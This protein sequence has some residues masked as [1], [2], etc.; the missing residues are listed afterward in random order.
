MIGYTELETMISFA[1]KLL[2]YFTRG[3]QFCSIM[4]LKLHIKI[5]ASLLALKQISNT[6][7]TFT[8][9]DIYCVE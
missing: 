7:L 3:T 1:I 8:G 9:F 5:L 2:P 4:I 6:V